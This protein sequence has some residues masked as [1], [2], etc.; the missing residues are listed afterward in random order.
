MIRIMLHNSKT[1]ETTWGDEK[2]LSEWM[3]NPDIWIWADFDNED[4]AHEKELFKKAFGLHSLAISDAQSE[5]HP[6]KLEAFDDYFF[7]LVSG[8]N[9]TSTG[10]DFGT[11]PI[12]FFVGHRFLVTRRALESISIDK[13]WEQAKKG[14][15]DLSNGSA[16][17]T[18]RILRQITDRY[19]NIVL[20][21][22]SRLEEMEDEMFE[23]P[24]DALLEELLGYGRALKRLRRIFEY[25]QHLFQKLSR[26]DNSFIEIK[27]HHEFNDVFE[28]TERLASLTILY[29]EL[30]DDLM[31]GY[32][33]VTSHRLNQIMKVLTVVTVIFL[34]LTLLA[35][36]YGMNFEYMPELKMKDAYFVMLGFMSFIVIS[37]L[38]V[39]RKM[40]WI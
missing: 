6:P 21:L 38:L 32:I 16:H 40:R 11:L 24:R 31:N 10:I 29:K 7:L 26:Q 33:S 5:R 18:Y 37:L 30:T 39:F 4:L 27:E 3:N 1:Q 35:G 17:V 25:H 28:H 19:T 12:S 36:I 9:K 23:N 2:L 20:G 22:E 14:N 34:P 15:I 8:L 13:I